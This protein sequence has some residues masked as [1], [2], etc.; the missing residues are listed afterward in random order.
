MKDNSTLTI[1]DIAKLANFSKATVSRALRDSPLI[2]EKTRQKIQLIA[3]ENNFKINAS[4]RSLRLQKTNTVAVI[5]MFDPQSDQAI[6]DPFMLEMLGTIADQLDSHG[7]DML[8]T[9]TKHS[10]TNWGG[11][12]VES[13]R[14]DGLIVIGQG[15]HDQRVESLVSDNLPVVVWGAEKTNTDHCVIGSN[16]QRGGYLA[17]NH[18]IEQGCKKIAFFGDIEYPEV[19][20]RWQG[21]VQ[22]FQQAGLEVVEE[23]Q[24]KTD[25]TAADAQLKLQQLLEQQPDLDGIFAVS[26]VIALGALKYLNQQSIKVPQQISVVGFDNI[27]M[28]ELCTPSLSTI[29]QSTTAGGK[30]L[31]K[32]LMAQINKQAATSQVLDVELVVR[33]SSQR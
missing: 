15:D 23:L 14:A 1:A 13:Q 6:S 33:D 26:D 9:T 11:Y 12:Y 7:Y 30:L 21:Y 4:A 29:S 18:L 24:I 22:A 2:N 25:F 28:A 10:A 19:A 31:V 27:A 3:K 8:L 5:I 32:N 16:N 17:V 20:I